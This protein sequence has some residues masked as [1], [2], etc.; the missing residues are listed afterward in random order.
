MTLKDKDGN[1]DEI[2][3]G[4]SPC[5]F[6]AVRIAVYIRPTEFDAAKRP[7]ISRPHEQRRAA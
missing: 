4:P 6:E 3:C 5:L 7:T 1:Y 2:V